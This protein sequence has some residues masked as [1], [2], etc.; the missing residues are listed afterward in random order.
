MRLLH[1]TY[2]TELHGTTHQPLHDGAVA[3]GTEIAYLA[4][5]G[6]THPVVGEEQ[7]EFLARG[8]DGRWYLQQC[9]GKPA[10]D[11]H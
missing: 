7:W 4:P 3:A 11:N 10:T 5:T 2:A 8:T 9:W 6:R 1:D